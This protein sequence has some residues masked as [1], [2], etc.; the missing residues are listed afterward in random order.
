MSPDF[1]QQ[2]DRRISGALGSG[3]LQ[4]MDADAVT[5]D[6]DGLAF[7]VRWPSANALKSTT[8]PPPPGGPRDPDFNPFLPPDPELTIGPVGKHH[9][10]ILN[11]FPVCARHLVIARTT[12]QEQQAGPAEDDFRAMAALL[13][14]HGG[15]GF[16]NC[17]TAAG[18]SQ[19]HKHVQWVPVDD[20]VITLRRY[21]DV[22]NEGLDDLT[23]LRHPGLPM[24]HCFVRVLAGEGIPTDE[25]AHSLQ[26]AYTMVQNQMGL[27]PDDKGLLP[28]FNLLV[29]EGWMLVVPR[30]QEHFEDISL[31]SLSYAGLFV[32][33][34]PE[35]VD[36][37]RRHGPLHAL[38]AVAWPLRAP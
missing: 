38:T 21:T 24:R 12:F 9:V 27:H 32:V 33:Q 26:A 37:I 36:A 8:P 30:R 20:D 2:V 10:A 15:L 28:P 11:K 6:D 7:V 17:G 19:P 22:F 23:L 18:S 25:S 35:Q 13:S 34:R 5:L 4:P 1:M 3:A 16:Y 29:E 31:N 14:S